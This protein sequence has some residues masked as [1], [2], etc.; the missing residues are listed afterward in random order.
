MEIN[1]HSDKI[2]RS[3]DILKGEIAKFVLFKTPGS[4]DK[5]RILIVIHHLA[6]D[7]VSWRIILDDLEM[8]ITGLMKNEQVELGVKSSSYR[9]WYNALEEFSSSERLLSQI[10]YWENAVS[11]IEQIPTDKDFTGEVKRRIWR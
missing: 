10:S 3:L 7:G 5:N 8:L 9:Q 11:D 2:Q 4:D 6:I 1:Y